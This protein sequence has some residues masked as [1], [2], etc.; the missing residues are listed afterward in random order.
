MVLLKYEVIRLLR[1]K[2]SFLEFGKYSG[3]RIFVTNHELIQDGIIMN[4]CVGTYSGSVDSG[5]CGIYKVGDYTLELRHRSTGL[6]LVQL[7]GFSNS[8]APKE[9][10]DEVNEKLRMFNFEIFL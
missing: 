9:V 2:N 8:L 5:E 10:I 7:M 1:V 6:Y 3:Y 4:H